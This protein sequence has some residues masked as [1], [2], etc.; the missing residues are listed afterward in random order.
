MLRGK[1]DGRIYIV[2]A[3][4]SPSEPTRAISNSDGKIALVRQAQA[5][6]EAFG[7]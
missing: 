3:N 7:L 6:T 5:F 2:D 1:G 4:N